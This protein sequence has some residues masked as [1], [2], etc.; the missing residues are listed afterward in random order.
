VK[1]RRGPAES[2]TRIPSR[3]YLG[4]SI[5]AAIMA[6]FLTAINMGIRS[7]SCSPR[8]LISDQLIPPLAKPFFDFPGT[9]SV[10]AIH[11]ELSPSVS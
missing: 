2:C 7:V 6:Q 5:L 4:G 3:N 10:R 1:S 8:S 9:R 11:P